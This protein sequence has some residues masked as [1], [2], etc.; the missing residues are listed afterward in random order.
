MV[1]TAKT[2]NRLKGKSMKIV[3]YLFTAALLSACFAV[4][5]KIEAADAPANSASRQDAQAVIN[6]RLLRNWTRDLKL[7]EEQQKGIR[8]L[9]DKQRERILELEKNES[10]T[11]VQATVKKTEF[12]TE[13]YSKI[14]PLL[15]AEQLPIFEKL[16][17]LPPSRTKKTS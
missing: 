7:T 15:T 13:T 5:P 10:L 9:L 8:Q 6:Q 1:R 2:K 4:L 3:S 12:R 14:K 11:P 16:I 17:A